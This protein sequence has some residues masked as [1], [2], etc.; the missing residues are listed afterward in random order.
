[1]KIKFRNEVPPS[2]S[3]VKNSPVNFRKRGHYYPSSKYHQGK[4]YHLLGKYEKQF[5]LRHRV[6]VGVRSLFKSVFLIP[7]FFHNVRD[8]WK[9]FWRGKRII[10][11]YLPPYQQKKQLLEQNLKLVEETREQV[12]KIKE[13]YRNNSRDKLLLKELRIAK[14]NHRKAVNDLKNTHSDFKITLNDLGLKYYI[15]R[16]CKKSEKRAKQ[17]WKKAST[18]GYHFANHNLGLLYLKRKDYA[19]AKH[20]FKI[21]ADQGNSFSRDQLEILAKLGE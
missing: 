15:G 14:S 2:Y 3:L 18:L 8:D 10:I 12:K 13:D 16:G 4:E 1:M 21:A 17:Y 9:S 19:K 20:Y 5:T 11:L 6:W 7:L